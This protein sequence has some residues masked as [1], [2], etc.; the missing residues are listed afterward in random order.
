MS[1]R[2]TII[3]WDG[4]NVPD[5]LRQLPAGRY[6]VEYVDDFDIT[7][8]TE[9]EEAGIRRALD[10]VDAGLT[11]PGAEALRAIREGRP[12]RSVV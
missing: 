1:L 7:E 3:E 11:L 5:N 4:E 6:I 9:E 8:L 10:Q 12:R 2:A